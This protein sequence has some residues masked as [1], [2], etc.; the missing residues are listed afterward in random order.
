RALVPAR[1]AIAE[2]PGA[3]GCVVRLLRVASGEARRIGRADAPPRLI[4]RCATMTNRMP[5][6]ERGKA[7]HA[8]FSP[9]GTSAAERQKRMIGLASASTD[10]F[11]K[12]AEFN[13]LSVT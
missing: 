13:R 1:C 2:T 9:A 7:A 8:L 6:A 4:A 3:D 5:F 11:C 10:K 12:P